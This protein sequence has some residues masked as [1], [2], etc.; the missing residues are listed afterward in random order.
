M[1]TSGN[2]VFLFTNFSYPSHFPYF[3]L[4][5]SSGIVVVAESVADVMR[6]GIHPHKKPDVEDMPQT[7]VLV[8]RFDFLIVSSMWF[9]RISAFLH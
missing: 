8:R 1:F 5:T 7:F 4:A 6:T 9:S 2:S 3:E